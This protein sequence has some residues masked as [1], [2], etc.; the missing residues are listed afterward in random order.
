VINENTVEERKL[1]TVKCVHSYIFVKKTN[2]RDTFTKKE[3]IHKGASYMSSAKENIKKTHNSLK[4]Q[5]W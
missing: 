4:L 5:I 2:V 3:R 1:V